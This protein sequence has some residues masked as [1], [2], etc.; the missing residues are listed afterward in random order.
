VLV[1]RT[2]QRTDDVARNGGLFCNHQCLHR[3]TP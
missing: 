3:A 1:E 2:R